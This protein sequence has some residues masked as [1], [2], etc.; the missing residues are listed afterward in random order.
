MDAKKVFHLWRRILQEPEFQQIVF[1]PDGLEQIAR[2]GLDPEEQEIAAA[3]HAQRE[4]AYWPCEGYRYRLITTDIEALLSYA[5]LTGRLLKSRGV[6]LRAVSQRFADSIG[7]RD[8]GLNYCLTALDFLSYLEGGD[9]EVP[10]IDYLPTTIAVDRAMSELLRRVARIPRT[11]W[12]APERSPAHLERVPAGAPYIR[13]PLTN[14]VTV[15]HEITTW[16][17][18]SDQVGELDLAAK[19][20][21][22][23]I[24]FLS[25]DDMPDF[26]VIGD[27]SDAL[28]QELERPHTVEDAIAVLDNEA[29]ARSIMR[30]FLQM[31]IIRPVVG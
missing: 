13:S 9:P 1:A 26:M 22:V 21:H 25:D 17:E 23:L 6:D 24:Q 16:L 11:E 15:A 20:Q 3:F 18:H 30:N 31:D 19:P 12:P 4:A 2:L 28:Y 10:E 8:D 29:L 27:N 14:A 7:W 5:P